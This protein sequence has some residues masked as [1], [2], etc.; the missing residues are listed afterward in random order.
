MSVA[1]VLHLCTALPDGAPL[2][3]QERDELELVEGKGAP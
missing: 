3:R 1:T 2:V